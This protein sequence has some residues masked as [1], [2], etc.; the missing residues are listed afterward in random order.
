V[1]NSRRVAETY[2]QDSWSPMPHDSALTA[3]TIRHRLGEPAWFKAYAAGRKLSSEQAMRLA[4]E[5][6]SVLEEEL[7]R[8][9]AGLTARKSRSCI[10]WPMG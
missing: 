2:Q 10:W 3:G 4:E 9:S 7:Q 1:W 5:A 6:V 8:R